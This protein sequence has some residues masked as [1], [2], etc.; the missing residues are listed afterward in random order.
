MKCQ[1]S[2]K[3]ANLSFPEPS[4]MPSNCFFCP[5]NSSKHIDSLFIIIND[6]RKQQILTFK[7]ANRQFCSLF[8]L[9]ND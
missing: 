8:Y 4:V 6:T 5:N 9:K 3:N 1:K 2:V 7:R